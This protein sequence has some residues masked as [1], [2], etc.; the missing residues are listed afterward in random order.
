MKLLWSEIRKASFADVSTELARIAKPFESVTMADLVAPS[1]QEST[2]LYFLRDEEKWAYVGKSESR[3][4]IERIP[5]HLDVRP[6][7][8]F[9]TLLQ[10]LGKHRGQDPVQCVKEALS[11]RLAVLVADVAGADLGA[12]ELAFRHA[13][14]PS[15]NAPKKALDLDAKSTY[16]ADFE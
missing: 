3:A 6:G 16:L 8:Y 14:R 15:L 13:F 5:S 10:K 11:L 2:G 7:S 4:F 12:A 1:P 9:G